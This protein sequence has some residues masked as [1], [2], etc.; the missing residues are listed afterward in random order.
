MPILPR[1]RG[2][3][4]Q[5]GVIMST[6]TIDKIRKTL[7][8]FSETTAEIFG[9]TITACCGGQVHYSSRKHRADCVVKEALAALDEMVSAPPLAQSVPEGFC[10]DEAHRKLR[11]N[12]GD[13]CTCPKYIRHPDCTR[14]EGRAYLP[15]AQAVPDALT[16]DE[17]PYAA[18][19]YAMGW[20]ACR[21]EMLSTNEAKESK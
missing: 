21:D 10:L 4:Q 9:N 5:Q 18:S 11:K 2:S 17:D 7:V 12:T 14:N 3:P 20:N 16:I 8:R 19:L 13:V 1:T 15:E 6:N